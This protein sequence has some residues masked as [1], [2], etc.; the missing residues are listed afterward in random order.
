MYCEAAKDMAGH[1]QWG[2]V[3]VNGF[4]ELR[5]IF[6]SRTAKQQPIIPTHKY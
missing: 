1:G 5:L 6:P 3:A 4:K 2:R